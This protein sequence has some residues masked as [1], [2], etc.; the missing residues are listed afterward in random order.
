MHLAYVAEA[1][2]I[3]FWLKQAG[4]DFVHAHFGTNSAEVAMLVHV[5]GGPKW[6]FTAHGPE[7]FEKAELIG[8]AEKIRRCA[9][10]VAI[11]A[12]ARSQLCRFSDSAQW[13]KIHIVHCGIDRTF[14]EAHEAPN[15]TAR[16]FVCIGRLYQKK[17]QTLLVEAARRLREENL[18]FEIVLAGDGELR[19]EIESLITKHGLGPY[20]RITGWLSG[21]QVKQE[22]LAARAMVLPSYSEGLPVVI[23]EA[24]ALRRPIISTYVAAIP[25]L[26]V[27]GEHGWLVQ[28]GDIDALVDAMRQ[29]LKASPSELIRLGTSAR[30]RVLAM[31]DVDV[32]AEKLFAALETESKA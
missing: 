16:R 26:V 6:S 29:C 11:S 23:M 27:P 13:P 25:E 28:P 30:E 14:S 5:L 4:V 20:V 24:M 10:V 12:Y 32:E 7:E 2:V 31:H 9:F 3:A 22:I 8:L 18:E 15:S 19:H 1:C 17:A 21:D